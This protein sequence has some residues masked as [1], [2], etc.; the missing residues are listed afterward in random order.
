MYIYHACTYVLCSPIA[1]NVHTYVC[2]Y[3]YVCIMIVYVCVHK[4][5]IIHKMHAL[6]GRIQGGGGLWGL[7][8]P[9]PPPPPPP[10]QAQLVEFF[11]QEVA[12]ASSA[13]LVV[14]K[15]I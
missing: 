13:R 3:V 8:P 12:L 14:A 9:P 10:L 2:V 5:I 6:Q 4:I 7:N 11:L 15:L 1:Y